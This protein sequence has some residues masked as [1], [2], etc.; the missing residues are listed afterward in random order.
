MENTKIEPIFYYSTFFRFSQ[1]GYVFTPVIKYCYVYA[2][3]FES[4]FVL[5]NFIRIKKDSMDN[6]QPSAPAA[7]PKKSK[8]STIVA[9]ICFLLAVCTK[10]YI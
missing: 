9:I 7:A 8:G 4:L 10:S 2:Y 1:C 5:Y 6:T 3:F